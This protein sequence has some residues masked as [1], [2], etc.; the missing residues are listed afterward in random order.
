M[1]SLDGTWRRSE[2]K[3]SV[4][5]L[6]L[7][8]D[9]MPAA[10]QDSRR[11]STVFCKRDAASVSSYWLYPAGLGLKPHLLQNP[12]E[13]HNNNT[14]LAIVKQIHTSSLLTRDSD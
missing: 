4:P 7:H 14:N 8:V 2:E 9:A 3:T 6:I 13:D 5:F 11:R 12:V 10:V 1:I